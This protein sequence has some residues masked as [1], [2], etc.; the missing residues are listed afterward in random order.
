M[1]Q[2]KFLRNGIF[3]ERLAAAMTEQGLSQKKLAA[4]SGVA[5]ATVSRYLNGQQEPRLAE[6]VGIS[7]AL[8]ISIDDLC[9]PQSQPRNQP[10]EWRAKYQEA[11]RKMDAL[12]EAIATILKKY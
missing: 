9:S 11:E 6:L 12:K 2:E 1:A 3:S 5:Q 10:N 7:L 8:G 4:M